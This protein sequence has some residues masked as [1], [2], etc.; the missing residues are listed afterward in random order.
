MNIFA[1]LPT[2]ILKNIYHLAIQLKNEHAR[3]KEQSIDELLMIVHELRSISHT[4]EIAT[5]KN[6]SIHQKIAIKKDED[7]TH[8]IY[9]RSCV[10]EINNITIIVQYKRTHYLDK[11]RHGNLNSIV[12]YSENFNINRTDGRKSRICNALCSYTSDLIDNAF[13]D[14]LIIREKDILR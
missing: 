2:E 1:E 14:A 6:I 13:D 8:I 4:I 11:N 12:P 5:S 10:A 9:R 7:Y 3:I